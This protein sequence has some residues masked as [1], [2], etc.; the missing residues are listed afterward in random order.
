MLAVNVVQPMGEQSVWEDGH[1]TLIDLRTVFESDLD[2]P[3]T[4]E[5]VGNTNETLADATLDAWALRVKHR[6]N[7]HGTAEIT[8]QARGQIDQELAIDTLHLTT[9][10]V[11]DPPALLKGLPEINVDEGAATTLDLTQYFRD[12]EQ[13]AS[14]LRYFAVA[15][16]ASDPDNPVAAARVENGILSLDMT[17]DVYGYVEYAISAM[18]REGARVAATLYVFVEPVNDPPIARQMPDRSHTTRDVS[19]VPLV[20]IDPWYQHLYD[21]KWEPYFSDVED[22]P[23]LNYAVSVDNPDVFQMVPYVD[24]NSFLLYR[25]TSAPGFYGSAV[26]T[27][28]ARDREGVVARLA[29]GS[30]PTFKV[31]VDNRSTIPWIHRD[32]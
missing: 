25:P 9:R 13:A 31:C 32:W 15:F 26:V 29:D 23:Y 11:N 12:V 10:P 30:L 7:Q 19:V 17:N 27:I 5:L 22:G 24:V 18:D 14:E 8:V 28:T 16:D 20:A 3:L 2:Q 21:E 1:D 4:Y 6:E